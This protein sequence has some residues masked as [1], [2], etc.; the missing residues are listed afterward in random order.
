MVPDRRQQGQNGLPQCG[1]EGVAL[2][3][4]QASLVPVQPDLVGVPVGGKIPGLRPAGRYDLLQIGGEQRKIVGALRLGP[5]R[6][7]L[8]HQLGE[9]RVLGSG[10]LGDLVVLPLQFPHLGGLLLVLGIGGRLL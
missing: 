6:N 3:D 2:G 9:G 7:A 10:D 1:E 8:L 4:G 5:D